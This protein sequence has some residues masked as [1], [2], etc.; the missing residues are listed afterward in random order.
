VQHLEGDRALVLEVPG[1]IHRSHAAPAELA[2]DRVAVG[3]GGLETV[4]R[5][6]QKGLSDEGLYR[7]TAER[8]PG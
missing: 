1:E 7:L 6:V 3:Q 4:Q 2:L 8:R 5:F